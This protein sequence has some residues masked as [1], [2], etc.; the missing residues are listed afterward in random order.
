MGD[1]N[2]SVAV[3]VVNFK[4]YSELGTC[5]TS[6]SPDGSRRPGEVIVIDHDSDSDHLAQLRIRFPA[7]RF[8]PTRS[9]PGFAAGVNAGSRLASGRYLLLVNPDV[10]LGPGAV[11][12]MREYLETHPA[13]GIVGARV[14]DPDGTVQR[15]A[16][17]FPTPLTGLFGRTSLL[18]RF[19]PGNP[20]SR[21]NLPADETATGPAEVDW[22]AGSCLMTRREVFEAV[23]GMDEG[24]FL[25]WEDADFCKRAR[26]IG[27]KTFYLPS[28]TVTHTVGG[29]SRHASATAVQAFHQSAYRYFAKHGAPR[30]RF[31]SLPLVRAL[32]FGRMAIKLAGLRLRSRLRAELR[33]SGQTG[34]SHG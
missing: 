2:E 14:L 9:N 23:G 11:D 27:W 16:R 30:V 1:T 34:P 5:L 3:V 25:Y 4:S 21:R 29:S 6:L 24:F 15:S 17:R 19:W 12:A 18:T 28:A 7:V 13:V 22:V 31:V 26:E 20:L 8:A 10:R 32:L 33:S